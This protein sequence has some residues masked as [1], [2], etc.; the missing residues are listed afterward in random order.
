[1]MTIYARHLLVA[2]LMIA[3]IANA[4]SAQHAPAAPPRPNI[5]GIAT[6]HRRPHLGAYGDPIARTPVLDR[7][8]RES[9]RYTH[10]F[11]TAPV[12]AP[13]RAAIITGMYQTTIGAQHMRTTE[14]RV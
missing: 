5:V 14:D 13:S 6:E 8:A 3:A 11:T 4:A 2:L 10:A 9:V 12:C 1:M 7:L